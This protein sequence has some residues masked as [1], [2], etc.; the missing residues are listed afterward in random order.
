MEGE[1]LWEPTTELR[2]DCRL[3]SYRD[4]LESDLNLRFDDYQQLWQWST[5]ELEAFWVS[6]WR[7]FGVAA[8]APYRMPLRQ[9]SMP[10]AR[11]FEG[12]TLNYAE[13]ALLAVN[14]EAVVAISE[15]GDVRQLSGSEL[16]R[17]VAAVAS[18]LREL[19][20]GMGDRVAAY[21]PNIPE[22]LVGFL[23]CASIGAI[24]SS[25]SPDFGERAVLDRFQQIEPVVLLAVDGYRY[26]GRD[27]DRREVVLRLRE[28]LPTVR[29]LI[30]VRYLFPDK[31]A[32]APG[33]TTWPEIVARE[34]ELE[35][36]A[37]PFDHPLWVV[38]SSGTTG[39]PKP[40]VHGHGG[41]L[42]EHLKALALHADLGP[43]SRFFWF[44]TTGWMMWNYLVSGLLVGAT[45]ILYDGSPVHP[46]PD[47]LWRLIDETG[48]T[49]FGTSAGLIAASMKAGLAPKAHL[50]LSSLRFLGSTGSP[51]SPDGFAWVYKEVK[52]DLW[53]SSLSGG[54]DLCTA[55]LLGCPWLPV[56]S[57]V[58]Q[59]RGL[60]ARVEAFNRSGA[61]VIGEVGEL[62]ITAPM[63]SMPIYFWGD[64]DGKRYRE[65]YFELYPGLWR[66]GDWVKIR[67]DGGAVIYG[68]SDST[69]NRHG[70]RMGTAEI[71]RAIEE[72]E[73]IQDCLV[74]DVPTD[75]KD[76]YMPLF[77]V[78]GSGV[79]L[80]EA[81]VAKLKA[82]IRDAV[83][84]RHV[85]D[86]VMAVP[87]IPKTLSGKKLEIPVKRILQ[88]VG[89]TDLLSLD[90]VQNPQ[91]LEPFFRLAAE[92]GTERQ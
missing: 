83:S 58:I 49:H 86:L 87:E 33:S 25:C 78:L 44:T 2:R 1:L 74:V 60:G 20:V 88:G 68:R 46:E 40:I 64:R 37:V 8:H 30:E 48:I 63:P 29:H 14:S 65:S 23:A 69:I 27:F 50:N 31:P 38:Y 19:G 9:R 10:G 70:V 61:A 76:S 62:I 71:Y 80:D 26:G 35:F 24:W 17:Q 13:H 3:S 67:P 85:P 39:L 12:A 42:L 28:G 53:L 75:G 21:V 54:T 66:H 77:V 89:T 18:H 41:I 73:E 5:E 22:A 4:W 55:F 47:R 79:T 57:G 16:R 81:L 36:T 7:F 51:L 90:A 34:A 72:M 92:R 52:Q 56:R 45:V 6:V 32:F 43:A 59:C 91:A 11:W 84:P 15:N 82:R